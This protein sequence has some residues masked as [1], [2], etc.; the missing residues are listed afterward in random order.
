LLWSC[1]ICSKILRKVQ[2]GTRP[3]PETFGNFRGGEN[4]EKRKKSPHGPSWGVID[5]SVPGRE[6]KS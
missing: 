2:K 4:G 1:E 5:K 6:K 3:L